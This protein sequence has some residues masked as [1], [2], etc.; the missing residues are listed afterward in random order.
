[1]SESKI[2]ITI[3]HDGEYC[4]ECGFLRYGTRGYW[5][6]NFTDADLQRSNNAGN[7]D[8]K[9]CDECI[10]KAVP[11]KEKPAAVLIGGQELDPTEADSIAEYAKLRF[12]E[13]FKNG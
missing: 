1:M 13:R 12:P 10:E 3:K 6:Q 7:I 2:E 5:C 4:G 8:V 11:V 9:R